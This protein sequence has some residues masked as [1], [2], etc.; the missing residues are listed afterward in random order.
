MLAFNVRPI[1]PSTRTTHGK[2]KASEKKKEGDNT[3]AGTTAK[4]VVTIPSTIPRR[5]YRDE[6]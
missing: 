5:P 4:T 1:R 6:T 2:S 3:M